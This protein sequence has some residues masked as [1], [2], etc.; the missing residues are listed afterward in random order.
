MTGDNRQAKRQFTGQRTAA[1]LFSRTSTTPST[2]KSISDAKQD[3]NNHNINNINNNKNLDKE[4]EEIE[5]DYL[6]LGFGRGHLGGFD[7]RSKAIDG[8]KNK[9]RV[10][11]NRYDDLDNWVH[12]SEK[13]LNLM[14]ERDWHIFKEDFNIT[15]KGGL[16]PHPLRSWKEASDILPNRLLQSILAAGYKEPT[17]IQR[18][19]IP[20]SLQN[21]DVIG[22]AQTGS[23]KTASFVI[24]MLYFISRLPPLTEQSLALGPY[25]LILAPT[26]ELA[27]QI[28]DETDKLI[29]DMGYKVTA[30][31]GGHSIEDQSFALRN[32]SHIIVATPGRL[33]D[34]LENRIIVLSQCIYVVL[35]EADK[36]LEIG[37]EEDLS[38]IL[39]SLPESNE[40][41]IEQDDDEIWKDYRKVQKRNIIEKKANA[42]KSKKRKVAEDEDEDNEE[43]AIA[44]EDDFKSKQLYRQTLMYS[45]TMLPNVERLAK[46]YLRRPAMVTIG[47][48]GQIVDSIVQK[49]ESIPNDLKKRKTKL[50]QILKSALSGNL[51]SQNM[52]QQAKNRSSGPIII[53]VNQRKTCDI[54]ANEIENSGN[55][56][57]VTLHGGKSQEQ[58]ELSL[59][60]LKRGVRK[61][62]V[63]TNVA[64]RGIDIKD[65]SLVINYDMPKSIEEYT[66][67]IGRTGRAGKDGLAISFIDEKED[68]EILYE[69]K[70]VL[71][72]SKI[73]TVPGWLKHHDLAQSK[74]ILGLRRK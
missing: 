57:C 46:Q 28:R 23:G 64:G 56:Q 29:R 51:Y 8:L 70:H 13:S 30:I 12:W 48:A 66:H 15:T 9:N 14:T 44:M 68:A 20:I 31:V 67:R 36:M 27:L 16:I 65:V 53:F 49:V 47:S 5:V 10:S 1:S 4:D 62:L 7:R 2:F 21:R 69:L 63:A 42:K 24:P 71:S 6:P 19:T 22:I 11:R 50:I 61:I 72:K 38:Y 41:P 3:I 55:L 34:C 18:Q 73:S 17:P 54:V 37:F 59:D 74:V 45:A 25:A 33:K 32:G 52:P 26:R 60:Q 58:R 39:D 43:G 35:D 40:K